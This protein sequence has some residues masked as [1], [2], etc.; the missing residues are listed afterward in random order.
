MKHIE[1]YIKSFDG[2]K[3]Y[4][5]YYLPEEK[6]KGIVIG[7]HGFGEFGY[8]YKNWARYFVDHGLGFIIYDQRGFGLTKGPR[9]VIEGVDMT[10]DLSFIIDKLKNEYRKIPFILYGHS[11]GGNI[12]LKY[13]CE[14]EDESNILI[15]IVASP[16]LQTRLNV[17]LP[18]IKGGN[19]LLGNNFTLTT[20]STRR[21]RLSHNY[22]YLREIDPNRIGHKTISLGLVEQMIEN[23]SYILKHSQ[24]IKVPI[25]LMS[26]GNDKVVDNR[27][28]RKLANSSNDNIT[29]INWEGYF[30]ELHN[31]NNKEL[32]FNE[33]ISYIKNFIQL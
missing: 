9:G 32:V 13:L 20:R 12:L 24:N 16:W 31:E 18:L 8:R 25:L 22:E 11:M 2:K 10:K 15:S 14:I 17:P 27:K 4:I 33:V 23:G 5:N 29:Y 26:S 28:I 19:K 21:N 6:I 3:L 1:K 7:V 30:H